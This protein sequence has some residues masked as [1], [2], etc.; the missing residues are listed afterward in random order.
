MLGALRPPALKPE[1]TFEA[2]PE[3]QEDPRFRGEDTMNSIRNQARKFRMAAIAL[4]MLALF[5]AGTVRLAHAQTYTALSSFQGAVY[6]DY[7]PSGPLVLGQDG[8]LYGTTDPNLTNIYGMTAAGIESP[9]W[10]S[11]SVGGNE[12]QCE[13]QYGSY[14]PPFGGMTVGADGLLYGTC[15]YWEDNPE[16]SI[17]Y[18]YD[19]SQGGNGLTVVYSFPIVG[20]VG[21]WQPSVLTLG[22]DGN[23]YGTA[24]PTSTGFTTGG[25]VFQFNPTT[26]K[27][28]TLHTFLGSASNDG[29]FPYGALALGTNGDFYGTTTSGGISGGSGGG[30]FYSIT[31]KGKYKVLYS[32]NSFTDPTSGTYPSAGVTLGNNGD[33]YGV[34]FEG[35]TYGQGTIFEITPAGKLT[36]MHNFNETTDNAGF[37]LFPLTLG[38]DGNLYSAATNNNGVQSIFKIATKPVKKIYTYTDLYNFPT[39]GS[40][41]CNNGTS[42]G[43]LPSSTILQL[44]N[45]LF[46]GVTYEGG[47]DNEGTFYSLNTGLKPFLLLQFP[48]GTEGTSLGIYGQGFI[49][50]PATA[51]SFNGKAASFTVVSDSYM[52]ATIPSGATKG[53]VTVTEPSGKLQSNREF[54]SKE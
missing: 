26:N 47:V 53:Y 54:T 45:G 2:I 24:I 39:P 44:P 41:N 35:G 38:S 34:T 27:L 28:T 7:Y 23:L 13:W 3:K 5:F 50:G 20:G 52:T 1:K 29:A 32:F 31:T 9:L 33:F 42:L 25:I 36:W 40:A 48:L 18:K 15:Q 12:G 11:G 30:T 51:V 8:N 6:G 21:Y 46:Y 14:D 4:T 19:P 17:I 43:C 10:Q 37:P 49:T 16:L 22:T